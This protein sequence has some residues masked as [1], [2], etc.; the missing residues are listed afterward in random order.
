MGGKTPLT[1]IIIGFDTRPNVFWVWNCWHRLAW[2]SSNSSNYGF[3]ALLILDIFRLSGWQAVRGLL[4][5]VSL[6]DTEDCGNNLC[7]NMC[8]PRAAALP[9]GEMALA[10]GVEI[11]CHPGFERGRAVNSC[12]VDNQSEKH[13][14]GLWHWIRLESVSALSNWNSARNHFF[15]MQVSRRDARDEALSVAQRLSIAF[16]CILSLQDMS[17]IS[18][19]LKN[20]SQLEHFICP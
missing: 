16:R 10:G 11:G 14:K 4:Q 18:S 8:K 19:L 2:N 7:G 5:S 17:R 12:H 15:D 13:R 1:L 9:H 3:I 6:E 20:S